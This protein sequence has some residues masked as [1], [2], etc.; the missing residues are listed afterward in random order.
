MPVLWILLTIAILALLA[1]SRLAWIWL[2]Y[3]GDRVITCPANM[4]SAGVR[5]DAGHAAASSLVKAPDLRL[6]ACTRWPEMAGCGQDCL[7][8]IQAAPAGCLVRNVLTE[9]YEAET[10]TSCGRLFGPINWAGPKPA[11]R[12]ADGREIEWQEVPVEQL[13]EVLA[14][15]SPVCFSCHMAGQ[16]MREHPELVTDRGRPALYIEG[17]EIRR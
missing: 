8:Q 6:C 10:C 12:A 2:K 16:L 15:G 7:K 11:I 4:R 9:W 3:R 13:Y 17:P 5:V 1:G 14:N